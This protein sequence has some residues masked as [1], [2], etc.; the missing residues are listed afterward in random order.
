MK[1]FILLCDGMADLP[2]VELGGKTPMQAAIK[3][4]MDQLA[5][6]GFA[7][8]AKTVPDHVPVGSDTANMAVMGYDPELYY[9]G[10]S[11]IEAVS[12][13]IDLKPDDVAFRVN[14]VTLSDD[15]PYGAKSMMDYSSDEIT[16]QEAA[17]LIGEINQHFGSDGFVFY[18]GISYRHCLVWSKGPDKG[19]L[20]PPHD[21]LTK[22]IAAYLPG[23]GAYQCLGDIMAE[24]YDFLKHHSVNTDRIARG[25]RPANSIWIW[26][27]GR[28][29]AFPKITDQYHLKGSVISAVDLIFGLGICAGMKPVRVEG[30]TGN[31]HTNFDGKAQ[32][33]VDEFRSGQD[34]VYLH[35]EAPDECGHRNELDNKIL[36]IEIIDQKVLKKVFE[37]LQGHKEE[38]G[39]DFRILVMPDHPTPI[40]LRTHTHDPV[41]FI[42][43]SSDGRFNSPASSYSELACLE[44]GVFFDRGYELF[45]VFIRS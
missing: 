42:I 15:Q 25:L 36:S 34:Y 18:P 5:A 10:R 37:Y 24:S 30:A 12:M 14:L 28:R 6:R 13:G 22:Q 41:P 19:D 1:Y 33:A 23:A 27:Q 21:I 7:G 31:I 39:E 17:V 2:I 9:T 38:T 29:P 4:M 43:Y 3:P 45:D 32:A 8:L 16:S 35:I 20:T 44:S 26:G 40:P 11:P